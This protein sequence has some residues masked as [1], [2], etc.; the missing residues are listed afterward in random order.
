MASQ[1]G[2]VNENSILRS[3]DISN[4]PSGNNCSIVREA[5]SRIKTQNRLYVYFKI[6]G[7][8]ELLLT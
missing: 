8:F 3:E 1:C 5:A 2:L 6:K 4:A 7:N